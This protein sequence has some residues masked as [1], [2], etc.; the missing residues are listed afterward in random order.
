MEKQK[1]IVSMFD[2]IAPTYDI[3]N[4]AL[5]FGV[6]TH[7]RKKGCE[8]AL[9]LL[10]TKHLTKIVD[11]ATGTG[12]MMTY[13]RKAAKM[14]HRQVDAYLG[15][16]PSE[17]ML[18]VAKQKFPDIEFLLASADALPLED[19]SADIISISYGIRNVV[20]RQK[21]IEEFYRVLKPGGALVILE[22]TKIHRTGLMGRIVD[23]Y[24]EEVLPLIGGLISRNFRAYRYLPD[25][26][27][28]FLTCESLSA[29]LQ[30]GGFDVKEAQSFS[31]NI[32]TLII[33]Q[34]PATV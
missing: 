1:T 12:D 10:E 27:E 15:I 19:A 8:L 30:N 26:I 22:F 25:S 14:L 33:A 2:E 16:D 11:V 23:F 9:Q 28:G 24:L 32:S 3:A 18:Y 7:W 34:K 29:E 20:A 13:W 5:S 21:A 6:D 4:R 31:F 17:G